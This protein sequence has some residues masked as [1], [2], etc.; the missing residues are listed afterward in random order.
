MPTPKLSDD[1]AREAWDAF[2]ANEHNGLAASRSLGIPDNTFRNRLKVAK[3]RGF[4]LPSGIQDAMASV[5]INNSN[6]ISG[7]WLKTKEASIQFRLDQSFN[8]ISDISDRIREA[9]S[10]IKSAETKPAPAYCDDDLL[11]VYPIADVHMGMYAWGEEVGEDYSVDIAEERVRSWMSSVI[12]ASPS[13]SVA[14]IL[15]VGDLHHADSQDN[16]TPQSK[17]QLDVDGR[18]FRAIDA[19]IKALVYCCDMALEK[20]QR[21][22]VRILPGNH[23][24]TSYMA[25]LFALAAHYRDEPRIEVQKVPGEFF[26]MDF[27]QCL[28]AAHHG[29]KS[30]P[31][32]MV[33]AIADRYGPQWGRTKH[34]FLFT[35]HLHHLKSSEIGGVLWQQLRAVAPK[36]AYSFNGAYSG[37]SEIRA[38]TIHRDHGEVL[39]VVSAC[40]P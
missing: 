24:P 20:H 16:R 39:T 2:V 34:R 31:E 23:N 33:L 4:H 3:E 28:I 37:K 8:E 17:H 30:K 1:L 26:I 27:G 21:V 35:G 36:D 29:D 12:S 5:G 19:S 7:G 32:R 10:S 6:M 13:S 14:V 25:T 15:D 38:M 40:A 18:H 11:T 9:L 22:I